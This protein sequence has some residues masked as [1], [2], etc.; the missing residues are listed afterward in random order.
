MYIVQKLNWKANIHT[1]NK[2]FGV[3]Q[4][5]SKPRVSLNQQAL[6]FKS[7]PIP[8]QLKASNLAPLR[9]DQSR[10]L[11]KPSSL[12]SPIVDIQLLILART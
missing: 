3:G 10:A 2:K 12:P 6:F 7:K 8:N 1:Q 5:E 11:N 9:T 4:V